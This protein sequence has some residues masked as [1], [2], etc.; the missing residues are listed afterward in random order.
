M[1]GNT[2]N[3]YLLQTCFIKA[4][5]NTLFLGQPQNPAG[6]CHCPCTCHEVRGRSG[7]TF[8]LILNLDTRWRWVVSFLTWSFYARKNSSTHWGEGWVG[9]RAGLDILERSKISCSNWE[10][11]FRLP[12]PKPNHYTDWAT[13]APEPCHFVI[14]FTISAT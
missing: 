2:H 11:S 5:K 12:S 9:P 10:L 4:E 6:L 7:I 14:N 1:C 8:P 3:K 13:L